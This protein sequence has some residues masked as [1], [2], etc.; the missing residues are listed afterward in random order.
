LSH[1]V[2]HKTFKYNCCTHTIELSKS[3]HCINWIQCLEWP[4]FQVFTSFMTIKA[5]KSL[6]N[7]YG[8][9]LYFNISAEVP[10]LFF[11]VFGVQQEGDYLPLTLHYHF[12]FLALSHYVVVCFV[13]VASLEVYYPFLLEDVCLGLMLMY[14]S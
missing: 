14:H 4:L 10:G 9:S 1:P 11:L 2:P 13:L 7:S 5:D 6:Y 12:Q 3:E 8:D